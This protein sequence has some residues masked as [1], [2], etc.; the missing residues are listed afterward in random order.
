MANAKVY[1]EDCDKWFTIDFT[2]TSELFDLKCTKCKGNNIWFG[3]I[4][5]GDN[6]NNIILGKGGVLHA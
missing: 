5:T 3:S 6:N 4:E 2:L 1:C